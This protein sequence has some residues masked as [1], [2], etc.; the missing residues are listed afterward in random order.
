MPVVKLW[1]GTNSPRFKAPWLKV[2][3][4]LKFQR[5]VVMYR[6]G[7]EVCSWHAVTNLRKEIE[8]EQISQQAGDNCNERGLNSKHSSSG[9]SWWCSGARWHGR[10]MDCGRHCLLDRQSID[11]WKPRKYFYTSILF[12][13]EKF[14]LNAASCSLGYSIKKW[15]N[16]SAGVIARVNSSLLGDES[17]YRG[18]TFLN[19]LQE[20]DST[21][22]VGFYVN[23][24]T[25]FGD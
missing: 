25:D 17:D 16:I 22:H 10:K 8:N 6:I 23:Q 9:L 15:G 12:N 5:R 11:R 13:G 14:I 7:H 3:P 18:N 19:G 20:T 24:T 21:V 1:L 2:R 4:R